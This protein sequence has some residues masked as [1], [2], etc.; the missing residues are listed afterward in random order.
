MRNLIK[1]SLVAVSLLV[2]TACGSDK[3]PPPR[4]ELIEVMRNLAV[5]ACDCG[6]DKDCL[7][8]VRAE[9]DARKPEFA[10]HGLTGEQKASFDQQLKEL[11]LCGDGGGVTIWQ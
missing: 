6:T 2:V 10:N 4:P 3:P 5:Q 1:H 8:V 11:R 7:R 9:Y